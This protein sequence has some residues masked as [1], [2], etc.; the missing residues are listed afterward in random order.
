MYW[1]YRVCVGVIHGLYGGVIWGY[2]GGCMDYTG[3]YRA[4][5]GL[6]EGLHRVLW[7]HIRGYAGVIWGLY[8]R[9]YGV[10]Y[11]YMRIYIYI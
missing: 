6:I 7:G 10:I 8:R 11:I 4:I 1:G 5:E 3:F 2:K 9:L